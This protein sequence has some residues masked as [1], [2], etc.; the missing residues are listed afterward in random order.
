MGTFTGFQRLFYPG[1]RGNAK[2]LMCTR[3]SLAIPLGRPWEMT[4]VW[5]TTTLHHRENR[6]ALF[7]DMRLIRYIG[8]VQKIVG[9]ALS[10][11]WKNV[12]V[13]TD[14]VFSFNLSKIVVI[15]SYFILF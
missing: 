10:L 11:W 13:S 8:L 14:C 3:R 4:E 9:L 2:G 1:G 5:F 6:G 7:K 12:M 15:I